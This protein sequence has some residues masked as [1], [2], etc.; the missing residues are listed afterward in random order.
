MADFKSAFE[1]YKEPVKAVPY[2]AAG[3]S[4][5]EAIAGAIKNLTAASSSVITKLNELK[6]SAGSISKNASGLASGL[7]GSGGLS[8]LTSGLGKL[9]GGGGGGGNGLTGILSGGS[10]GLN[11]DSLKSQISAAQE[12]ASG[13]AA[14]AQSM[15]NTY[16]DKATGYMAQAQ[17]MSNSLKDKAVAYAAQAQALAGNIQSQA[18]GYMEKAQSTVGSLK[19]QAQGYV[20]QAQGMVSGLKDQAQGYLSQGQGMFSSL[21]DRAQGV[22]GTMQDRAE[23]YMAQA[24]GF[25]GALQ[26]QARDML[27]EIQS[28]G[29]GVAGGLMDKVK[30]LAGNISDFNLQS[31]MSQLSEKFN[32]SQLTDKISGALNVGLPSIPSINSNSIDLS[33]ITTQTALLTKSINGIKAFTVAEA[34][35][36]LQLLSDLKSS[37]LDDLKNSTVNFALNIGQNFI[38][39]LNQIMYSD[40][41]VVLKEVQALYNLGSDLAYNQNYTRG[42]ALTRDWTY[43][44]EFCDNEYKINYDIS[45]KNLERDLTLA[46]SS[47]SLNN[48]CYILKR[49][50]IAL[51]KAKE[52]LAV[53]D[54]GDKTDANKEIVKKTSEEVEFYKELFP[55][56]MKMLIIYSTQY[57]NASS[58]KKVCKELYPYFKPCQLGENDNEFNKKY[59]IT[60]EEIMEM[61]PT[62][63]GDLPSTKS[64]GTLA[65]NGDSTTDMLSKAAAAINPI[66]KTAVGTVKEK[67][68][69]DDDCFRDTATIAEIF[70]KSQEM[71][72][73]LSN[74]NRISRVRGLARS[75]CD[76]FTE[77]VSSKATATIPE[78][79]DTGIDSVIDIFSG[80]D[81]DVSGEWH[82][83][84]K[85]GKHSVGEVIS[86]PNNQ[87]DPLP[88]TTTGI[89]YVK[90]NNPNIKLIYVMLSSTA[91][92][93]ND[94]LQSS[95]FYIRL[96]EK[97]ID[98]ITNA[99]D[100]INT[101][102][103]GKGGNGKMFGVPTSGSGS[104]IFDSLGSMDSIDAAIYRLIKKHEAGMLDPQKHTY[105]SFAS[106]LDNY[107]IIKSDPLA[108]NLPS[109][110][111]A[112]IE[113]LAD[114]TVEIL[115][116][117]SSN[118]KNSELNDYLSA[119]LER[120]LE[121]RQEISD[122]TRYLANTPM[123]KKRDELKKYLTF[124]YDNLLTIGVD[125]VDTETIFNSLI[126]AI[127]GSSKYNN[128]DDLDELF[129]N[130][131]NE[132]L[133]D[134]ITTLETIYTLNKVSDT[135]KLRRFSDFV[136]ED[137]QAVYKMTVRLFSTSARAVSFT[138]TVASY[139]S[140][141]LKS[142]VK[143]KFYSELNE[144][145]QIKSLHNSH[146]F[147]RKDLMTKFWLGFD[148]GGIF[149]YDELH[150]D[151]G[152]FT[153]VTTGDYNNILLSKQGT[154]FCGSNFTPG[155][156]IRMVD[157]QTHTV[158]QTNITS[159]NW[160]GT[161]SAGKVFFKNLDD[162][163][164]YY[165]DDENNIVVKTET[166]FGNWYG[167]D[168]S[169]VDI[170]L[171]TSTSSQGLMVW[172]DLTK[173][174]LSTNCK[175]GANYK[176]YWS[177]SSKQYFIYND[178]SAQ[179]VYYV[180][181]KVDV[182]YGNAIE[183]DPQTGK[184][185]INLLLATINAK[186]NDAKIKS[187]GVS[188]CITKICE[189]DEN[190]ITVSYV[191]SGS[192][193]GSYSSYNTI[194]VKNIIMATTGG[195]YIY[196]HLIETGTSYNAGTYSS[197][198][199]DKFIKR[200][201]F[202]GGNSSFFYMDGSDN[203]IIYG[204]CGVQYVKPL[205]SETFDS[206][207]GAKSPS[208]TC[209]LT[210]ISTISSGSGSIQTIDDYAGTALINNGS[211]KVIT[212]NGVYD[213]V[214]VLP[215]Y[216]EI[217]SQNGEILAIKDDKIYSIT[218][219]IEEKYEAKL[220]N[221]DDDYTGWHLYKPYTYDN[222]LVYNND[223]E[224]GIFKY[225]EKGIVPTSI[226]K[227][228]WKFIQT[229]EHIFAYSIDGFNGIK[230]A[231]LNG[232][233]FETFAPEDS[234]GH[235]NFTAVV[236]DSN[237]QRLFTVANRSNTEFIFDTFT[238]DIDEFLYGKTKYE[239]QKF[240]TDFEE[241]KDDI[242]RGVV[243]DKLSTHNGTCERTYGEE[244][245]TNIGTIAN[246]I[247][248]Q[249]N[250]SQQYMHEIE[251]GSNI[252]SELVSAN[253]VD[254]TFD[255][256]DYE[257]VYG[258]I[259]DLISDADSFYERLRL[260]SQARHT[261]VITAESERFEEDKVKIDDEEYVKL[262]EY[263]SDEFLDNVEP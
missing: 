197:E 251:G 210:A 4:Y 260:Q 48:L 134:N 110:M 246:E 191:S 66:L 120:N 238:Y 140:N 103:N 177:A 2:S 176:V 75:F 223:N 141:Y 43:I 99:L 90:Y 255:I 112:P 159:G 142:F 125:I 32:V 168:T 230:Y 52:T 153:N 257:K 154:F 256:D 212:K 204:G 58:L 80:S 156:G 129:A 33:S 35:K 24:K 235:G 18:Q 185:T 79:I 190:I 135:L 169:N 261:E 149:G 14:Q 65:Y 109:T 68:L 214:D 56:Y 36:K 250:I 44:L 47:S 46:A 63:G 174:F 245:V 31:G 83:V 57:V 220:L 138:K 143:Q 227:G 221:E 187:M 152:K 60:L 53:Y 170:P 118:N 95:Y 108:S 77:K 160:D 172:N 206:K 182:D 82:P 252:Y 23:A 234:F 203:L 219:N 164:F 26:G 5:K 12:K 6:S 178:S 254:R 106:L 96:K 117:M 17:S 194:S 85:N 167:L 146:F 180:T 262:H 225:V 128:P 8:G 11:L 15:A 94:Y 222:I 165:W 122:Q 209:P 93:G 150:G 87:C 179:D 133:T 78:M 81:G 113:E 144:L 10:N 240:V 16:K 1:A 253:L 22:V 29:T 34:E 242:E 130:S 198:V 70:P 67:I 171:F 199:A 145:K 111:F 115:Q 166:K 186:K 226:T 74:E 41:R 243:S 161:V 231:P 207:G 217:A 157:E 192:S 38:Q 202:C 71:L 40:E 76:Q 195:I 248:E 244:E 211:V 89:T 228:K 124:F 218:K 72:Y 39:E 233:N 114:G 54:L 155:N 189:R 37:A 175:S 69:T 98:A 162:G 229:N 208:E 51:E 91:I 237:K 9:S 151:R 55:K 200:Q 163:Y 25:G 137:A 59:M 196:S 139:D 13:L 216:D 20:S 263:T 205:T 188:H 247:E 107:N 104:G 132:S 101:L 201:P 49:V 158:V 232:Y 84:R 173:C 27:S 136:R 21:K 61:I 121:A 258:V 116:S 147:Q 183:T 88:T 119:Q 213:T 86:D 181:P 259:A 102:L 236:W 239:L 62:A 224:L 28:K 42:L 64:V 148:N 249:T 215:S 105:Q 241:E 7:G 45:Y 3:A 126:F 193:S 50:I 131:T 127:F 97:T 123:T 19:E 100:K 30:D 184:T 73:P 92:W